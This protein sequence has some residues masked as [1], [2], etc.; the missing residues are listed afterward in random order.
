MGFLSAMVGVVAACAG[1][2]A[3][4]VP[5]PARAA[6]RPGIE[7]LL[8]D[9]LGLVRGVRIGLVTNRAGV[10]AA[11]VSDVDRLRAAGLDLV[12]LFSPEHGFR[13]TAAP[14]ELVANAVDSATSLPIY[15][16]YGRNTAP[17]PEMLAGLDVIVVDLQDVGARYYT[18]LSTTAAVMRSAA[19]DGKR[20][21]VLDRP[22]PIGG[23]VQGNVLDTAYAS[24]VGL[25]PIAMRH[26]M[27]L[28]ELARLANAELA[29]G[30]D[31][32]VVPVAGWNPAM[33]FDQ[34]GLPFIPPSPN[35][36]TIEALFHYPGLCLFEGTNL[37][38]GRGSEHPFEQV[39]APW[40]DARRVIRALRAAHLPGVAFSRVRF[41]PVSPGDGKYADTLLIGIRLTVTDRATYD[42]TATAVAL[43]AAIRDAHPDRLTWSAAQFDRLAGTDA[44]RLGLAS[45]APAAEVMSGWAGARMDFEARR[46]SALIYPREPGGVQLP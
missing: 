5:A 3:A 30:A 37:S 24:F 28:G 19:R 38:V 31:L 10:D 34:T 26:G 9:S 35:L 2:K 16:L 41:R 43:M 12:A 33:A 25:L 6:V 21:I 1:P 11:G 45:G 39:G 13:G 40:L 42:P 27:T 15:S 44:L 20:V 36:R 46:A 8:S 14:G 22:N 29:I 4:V 23:A 7:V 17:T 32:M 18:Y